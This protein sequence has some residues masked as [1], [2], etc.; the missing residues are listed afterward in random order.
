MNTPLNRMVSRRHAL[1]LMV[2]GIVVPRMANAQI[3]C[4]NCSTFYQQLIGYAKDAQ[5]YVTQ[6]EQYRTQLQSYIN[7]VTNTIQLPM[8]IWSSVQGDIMQVQALSNAGSLLSGNSGSLIQRLQSAGAYAN[9]VGNLANIGNQFTMYQ[10]A[11]GNNLSQL[12]RTLGIQ[13]GQESNNAAL[14]S[15]LQAHSQNAQ[16]QMQA[17][18][19]GNELAHQQATQLLQ[20]QATLSTTAQ[21]QATKIAADA[22][23]SALE[24]TAMQ[25]FAQPPTISTTGGERF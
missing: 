9:Q 14:L 13:Q 12:G 3:V 16:G 5:K 24:D 25:Q 1:S 19:A 10:N 22:D 18:Q 17:I 8:Q 20:I 21:M 11:I 15:A 6:L 7:M 23:R 4:A 2:A